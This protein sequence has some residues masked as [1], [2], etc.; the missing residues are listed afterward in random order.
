[1]AA[2]RKKLSDT[3]Q[4]ETYMETLDYPLK[5]V[6][7]ALREIIP[8][9]SEKLKEHIKPQ[10]TNTIGYLYVGDH[11]TSISESTWLYIKQALD[12]YKKQ[13]PLFIILELNTP[14]RFSLAGRL[15][16]IQEID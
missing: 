2:K 11:E 9:C 14:G 13:P 10:E 8:A 6:V 5:D 4:V 15:F 7:E 12:H 3:E 16:L 1:M